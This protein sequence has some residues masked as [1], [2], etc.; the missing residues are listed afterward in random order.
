MLYPALKTAFY[1]LLGDSETAP[2][3]MPAATLSGFVADAIDHMARATECLQA[4]QT[5]LVSADV[6][7]YDYPDD[8]DRIYAA[9]YDGSRLLPV[10][11]SQLRAEDP[12]WRAIVGT[13]A[14]YYLDENTRKIGLYPCPEVGTEYTTF[15]GER[16]VVVSSTTDGVADTF[17]QELGIVIDTSEDG[18]FTAELGEV[19]SEVEGLALDVHYTVHGPAVTDAGVIYCPG[20]AAHY[21]LFMAL[22]AALEADTPIQNMASAS[23]WRQMADFQLARIRLR[24]GS[25]AV[26]DWGV[27]APK[28]NPLPVRYPSPIGS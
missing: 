24:S 21:V 6:A 15:S 11:Q 18:T 9:Y 17:S 4:R 19:V 3:Y 5:I 25:R 16:G 14:Y 1:S 7:E 12:N 13:P 10:M 8:C 23:F 27:G 22:S 2:A 28:R 20:W 26:R